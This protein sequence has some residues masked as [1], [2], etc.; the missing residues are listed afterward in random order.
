MITTHHRILNDSKREELS[1][2]IAS[3]C[4]K[5]V[6]VFERRRKKDFSS[7]V[8]F[9]LLLLERKKLKI[10]E[11]KYLDVSDS[12]IRQRLKE[13]LHRE[14]KRITMEEKHANS[15]LEHARKWMHTHMRAHGLDIVLKMLI[16]FFFQCSTDVTIQQVNSTINIRFYAIYIYTHT[17]INRHGTVVCF[18]IFFSSLSI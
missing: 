11:E 3:S 16:F 7:L 14:R 5:C 8:F 9:S 15:L 17:H 13:V 4:L 2:E 12:S 6:S 18:V 10:Y 1:K